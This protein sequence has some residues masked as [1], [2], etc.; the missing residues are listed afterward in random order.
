LN[1]LPTAFTNVHFLNRDK[2]F[3]TGNG[4][5]LTTTDG[6]KN[7][8]MIL[9]DGYAKS[10]FFTND[11]VGFILTDYGVN[12]TSDGGKNWKWDFISQI[13]NY[14][15]QIFFPDDQVG[16]ITTFY[17]IHK[18]TDGGETWDIDLQYPGLS[19]ICFTDKDDGWAVGENGSIFRFTD[20]QG[21]KQI[22]SGYGNQLN[23]VFFAENDT[24]W[25]AGGSS[26]YDCIFLK[27]TDG[28]KT[29]EKT[30]TSTVNLINDFFF[31]DTQHGWAV[32]QN[33]ESRG[34]VLETS[35]GGEHWTTTIKNL[36]APLKAIHFKDGV[37]WA[38]G[39]NGLILKMVDT[40]YVT[41]N[42]HVIA[43]SGNDFLLQNYPNPFNSV[44]TITWQLAEYSQV[45]LKVLDITG[46]TVATLVD[47]Q[48]PQGKYET[49]FNAATLPKGIYF[50]QLK[51]GEFSQTRKMILVE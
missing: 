30:S 40:T 37:G 43:T 48:R 25:I 6:G 31:K 5:V 28:G 8:S 35:D 49:Q 46:R 2:G 50:C 21:W 14:E 19:G 39:D 4:A 9:N 24:G 1:N 47:E 36:S 7:W 18:T 10:C 44:T 29:W 41:T 13:N 38:V 45:T 32:G 17:G 34:V 16:Y 26:Y 33:S 27:T 12:R 51:A 11:S 23:K 42:R 3:V 20:A 15:K 22:Y